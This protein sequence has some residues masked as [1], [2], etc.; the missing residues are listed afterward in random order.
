MGNG[1]SVVVAKSPSAG[2]IPSRTLC[3]AAR[4]LSRCR[5]FWGKNMNRI[6]CGTA[7]AG[8][9]VITG[10]GAGRLRSRR[11]RLF[12]GPDPARGRARRCRCRRHRRGR[13]ARGG[14][15]PLPDL[16]ATVPGVSFTRNGPPG[17]S[18]TLRI[19]GAG[20]G[21]IAVYIDGIAV[22]DPTSTSGQFNGF[23]SLTTGALRRVEILRGSQSSIFGTNAVAGVV[24]ITT[25]ATEDAPEGTTQTAGAGGRQLRHRL[26]ELRADPAR[27]SAH[28]QLRVDPQP[29]GRVLR[30]RGRRRQHRDRPLRRH[31]PEPRR[32]LRGHARADHRR[33]CLS[34]DD[35]QRVRRVRRH[36]ARGRHAGR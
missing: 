8:D 7:L 31:A 2:V 9:P 17:T 1:L 18:T 6:L 34:G 19:R 10:D 13:P 33:Q 25:V 15:M 5:T 22:N 24:S 36:R 16:L 20:Q 30:R 29:D 26:G 11:H 12:R 4:A 21:L 28:A 23:D 3:S 27:G 35:E 14:R 32:D